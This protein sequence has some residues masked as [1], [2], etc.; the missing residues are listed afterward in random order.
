MTADACRSPNRTT[1]Y[2][3]KGLLAAAEKYTPHLLGQGNEFA[4]NL[5]AKAEL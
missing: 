4:A 5:A 3:Q 1:Q 2:L